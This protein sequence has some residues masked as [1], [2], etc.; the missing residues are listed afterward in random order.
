[1]I[2]KRRIRKVL[3]ILF[4][5]LLVV[6][7]MVYLQNEG[8][9]YNN[10][11]NYSD[12]KDDTSMKLDVLKSLIDIQ[13][14]SGEVKKKFKPIE[15]DALLKKFLDETKKTDDPFAQSEN[16]NYFNFLDFKTDFSDTKYTASQ[17]RSVIIELNERQLVYNSDKFSKRAKEF[18]VIVVQVHKR[19]EYFKELLDSLQRSK[20][21]ENA[22]L[23]ISHDV[24]ADSVNELIRKITFCQVIQIFFPYSMQMYPNEYPG[25]S[26]ND[27][28]RDIALSEARRIGCNNAET[29]DSFGHYREAHIT[30]TKHHW[31]WKINMVMDVLDATKNHDGP[32]MFIEEDHYMAPSFYESLMNLHKTKKSHPLC[33]TSCDILTIGSYAMNEETLN[34]VDEAYIGDWISTQHNMGMALYRSTWNEIKMCAEKFCK[35]DDYNWD[36][37]IMHL[38]LECLKR[39]LSVLVYKVPRMY[40]IGDCGLHHNKDC[41]NSKAT[42]IKV[43]GIINKNK[44]QME[45]NKVTLKESNIK[46]L[47]PRLNGGW[48]DN[49]DHQLCLSFMKNSNVLI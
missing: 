5:A 32:F 40:H 3:L 13:K 23:V 24:Y 33:K 45:N 28:P 4:P 17:L 9:L 26:E 30:M 8:T 19:I 39:K 25:P 48:G 20:G 6:C 18:V 7:F 38:S 42:L 27:C 15:D 2:C 10:L 35:Y 37:T 34:N 36:W 31:W 12:K 47:V 16:S 11:E 43:K 41:E 44:E 21:I 1:M 29:P 49:R 46:G 14:D 22:I